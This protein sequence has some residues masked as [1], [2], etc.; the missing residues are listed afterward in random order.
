MHTFIHT[1]ILKTLN[2]FTFLIGIIL[3]QTSSIRD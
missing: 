1:F 3:N 2:D